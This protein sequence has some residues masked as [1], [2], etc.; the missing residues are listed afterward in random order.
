[1]RISIYGPK[2]R[3]KYT[4]TVLGNMVALILGLSGIVAIISFISIMWGGPQ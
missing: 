1:M 3:V 2:R 4:L